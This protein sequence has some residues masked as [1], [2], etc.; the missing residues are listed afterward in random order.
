MALS[1][2]LINDD[3]AIHY[4]SPLGVRDEEVNICCCCLTA[5]WLPAIASM[6]P[7]DFLVAVGYAS[8]G[9]AIRS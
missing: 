5:C 7:D 4:S 3:S 8:I 9:R 1:F 6:R 2:V